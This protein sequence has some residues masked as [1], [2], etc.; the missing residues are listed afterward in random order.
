MPMDPTSLMMTT[1]GPAAVLKFSST[2]LLC[3][4]VVFPIT[5]PTQSPFSS[6]AFEG[7]MGKEQLSTSRTQAVSGRN[8]VLTLRRG[9][10]RDGNSV[11][12]TALPRWGLEAGSGGPSSVVG[13]CNP[14]SS[15]NCRGPASGCAQCQTHS[16]TVASV[17][18]EPRLAR[19]SSS[20]K[21][22]GGGSP[23]AFAKAHSTW[24]QPIRVPM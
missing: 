23:L 14:P 24:L 21:S 8:R 18:V 2:S 22:G 4:S 5:V 9:P 15:A 17:L 16:S 11:K 13:G 1:S 20:T 7:N 19:S 6:N 12:T 10:E 3:F